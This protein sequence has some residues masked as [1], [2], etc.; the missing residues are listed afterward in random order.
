V[1]DF[2]TPLRCHQRLVAD[3][4]EEKRT[5]VRHRKLQVQDF[6]FQARLV[7]TLLEVS[8]G[9]LFEREARSLAFSRSA[10]SESPGELA[11]RLFFPRVL[12][13][14]DVSYALHK[15]LMRG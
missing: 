9:R 12:Y 7:F 2:D 8:T 6:I 15:H 1:L 4:V 13:Q 11:C 3:L 14:S 5:Y 10:N